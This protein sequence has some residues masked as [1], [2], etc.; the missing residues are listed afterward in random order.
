MNGRAGST[1]ALY[2]LLHCTLNC[3]LSLLSVRLEELMLK[4]ASRT[5]N[6]FE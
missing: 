5:L 3:H 1:L 6:L 2:F 4:D